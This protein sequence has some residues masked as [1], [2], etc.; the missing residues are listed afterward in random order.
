[1]A[2]PAVSAA[3]AYT[4]I[5]SGRINVYVDPMETAALRDPTDIPA[6]PVTALAQDSRGYLWLG[7][8]SGPLTFDG[9]Y[10]ASPPALAGLQG[11]IVL[12][13]CFADERTLWM[14]TRSIGLVKIRIG[15]TG[16]RLEQVLTRKHGLPHNWV[17]TVC[18]DG[19]G[20]L[21]AGTHDGIAI[22]ENG[23]VA[24]TLGV[25]DGLVAPK[26]LSLCRD[27]RGR[28][29]IGMDQGLTIVADS[30]ADDPTAMGSALLSG[31]ASGLYCD[32]QGRVWVGTMGGELLRS[33]A[34]QERV[35]PPALVASAGA[36]ISAICEDRAGRL[37][38][39]TRRGAQIYADGVLVDTITPEDGLPSAA[40]RAL[41]C[42]RDGRVWA[43]TQHG[44]VALASPGRPGHPL[45]GTETPDK[46]LVWAFA[47][48]GEHHMWLGTNTGLHA[49]DCSGERP[50]VLPELPAALQ[51]STVWSLAW[52]Q[53]GCLCV[54]T[55]EHGLFVLDSTTGAIDAHLL[56][57][58]N[59]GVVGICPVG[60]HQLWISTSRHGV[61]C[62]D[63]ATHRILHE[64]GAE[65]GLADAHV[66]RLHADERGYLWA[67]TAS[68][69]L[70]CIDPTRGAIVTTI[71]LGDET[72]PWVVQ[73]TVIDDAGRIWASTHG[74]GL[75]CADPRSSSIVRTVTAADGLRSNVVYSCR[76][77]RRGY[78]WLGTA[79]G[80]TRFSPASGRCI[81]I[82]QSLGLPHAECDQGALHLD[83][84]DR[85]WVG[86]AKGAAVVDTT[87]VPTDVPASPVYLVG[88]RVMGEER[89]LDHDMAIE[90]SA[91]DL[92]FEYGAVSFTAPAGVVYRVQ[93]EGLEIDWSVPTAQRTRRYTNLRPGEYSF[94]V[95]ACNWG[96]NWCQPLVVPF[97]VIQNRQAREA[98]EALERERI[99]KEVYRATATRLEELNQQ[100][101]V[102]QRAAEVARVK[103]EELAQ[104]RSGFIATVSHELRTPLTAIIGYGELLTAQWSRLDDQARLDRVGRIVTAANRQQRLVEELLLLS[105][106]EMGALAP[107]LETVPLQPLV[108]RAGDEVRAGYRSQFIDV[109]GPGDLAVIAD[110]DRVVQIL[111]NL[112]DNAT[113]Y[114]PEGAPV[115]VRWLEDHGHAVVRVRDHG[116]GVPAAG[117]DHLFTRFGRISGT[118]A[119]PGHVGTGLGL[120]LGRSLAQAM[121]GDLELEAT[122]P[123]GSV[124]RLTLPLSVEHPTA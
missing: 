44:L 71:C 70:V 74:G 35:K 113:K 60:P 90:D 66:T 26:V 56:E 21:W 17:Q 59:V 34:T 57:D 52:D 18:C 106:L 104:L 88:F 28:L 67:G 3:V 103:A 123:E 15:S 14:G 19:R 89:D 38:V 75:V 77:D 96:G 116:A 80:V 29:W 23:S 50:V 63:S 78:L 124:F 105:R 25:R 12:C 61:I 24:H 5:P 62:I 68:G 76:I 54:G 97:R 41:L 114:S 84:N 85:L 47:G 46:S 112:I 27:V 81:T 100:L 2:Q 7:S 121:G 69:R 107:N 49:V 8:E 42:D 58:R 40:I 6:R 109:A 31:A 99:A 65:Q 30:S 108:E 43:G 92:Q 64:L 82:D 45:G 20:R 119:R 86:T 22:I 79:A 36:A 115:H 9:L 83:G 32:C 37:Y 51:Q 93:L 111:V 4:T 72:R 73:D 10:C 91:Y 110:P 102:A 122:G 87:M 13:F 95:S 39:G 117:R 1:M 98:A 33:D 120:H 48:D 55:R 11:S 16:P 118:Q 53:T 94:R 101:A